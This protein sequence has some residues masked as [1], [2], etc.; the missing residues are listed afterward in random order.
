MNFQYHLQLLLPEHSEA[1]FNLM[2]KVREE[3][4]DYFPVLCQSTLSES[5]TYRFLKNQQ[6]HILFGISINN[7]ME[8]IVFYKL[9]EEGTNTEVSYFISSRFQNQGI[10]SLALKQSITLISEKNLNSITANISRDNPASIRIIEK[11]GFKYAGSFTSNR[12][13]ESKEILIFI[14]DLK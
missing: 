14:R 7:L 1:L 8:G 10:V 3:L 13:G 11:C 2:E 5:D 4:W 12:T 6:S 9:S